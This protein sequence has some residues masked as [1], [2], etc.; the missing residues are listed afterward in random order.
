MN[1][2][3]F[4]WIVLAGLFVVPFIPFFV[5][6]SLFFPYITTKAF[7]WRIII[8]IIFASWIVLAALVPEYRPKKTLILYALL[9]FLVII[10][11]ADI[12]GEN[13]IKSI[14]SN[15]ER[16]EGFISL[17]HLGAFFVVIS[18]V[19]D[20]NM[21]K[22]WWNTNAAVS[23]LM[24]VYCLFQLG[25]AVE[26]HQGGVRVDGTF[27]NA[28]YLAVYMLINIFISILLLIRTR[29]RGLRWMYGALTLGQLVILYYTAT[30]G[31]ILGLLGGILLSALIN[32]FNK[33]DKR[34][35]KLSLG[36]IGAMFV[37]T[38]GFWAI[39]TT[40]FVTNSPVLSRFSS[41]NV[42]QIK[43]E[44]RSFIWPMA[45]EGIKEKP[46]LGWGQENF[47][48]VFN[49]HYKPEMFRL[50]PWFDR[51]HNIF[52][53]WAIAGGLLGLLSYLSL[54]AALLYTLWKK[55]TVLSFFEKSLMTGMVAAYFFH[56]FFVFDHLLSYVLFGAILAYVDSHSRN[57]RL[58]EN[59]ILK[60]NV[61]TGVIGGSAVLM[62]IALYFVNIEPL[63]GNRS[64]IKALSTVQGSE[65][66]TQALTYFKDA[67]RASP[68]GRPEVVEWIST[69]GSSVNGSSLSADEKKAYF[70]FATEVVKKQADDFA[71]DA[72]YQLLAG[73]LLSQ[74]GDVQGAATYLD[75]AEKLIPGKQQ[76]YYEEGALLIGVGKY[77]EALSIF[78]KAYDLAPQNNE[79]AVLYLVGAIYAKNETLMRELISKIPQD[80]ILQ[81]DSVIKALYDTKRFSDLA[82]LLEVRLQKNP[83]NAQNYINLSIAYVNSGRKQDAIAVLNKLKEVSP[84]YT[85]DVDQYIEAINEGKI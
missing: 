27:G 67:Y 76:V 11:L 43:T 7:S 22:K 82:T 37:L 12:L 35:K 55:D 23:A 4:K 42:N 47:N 75:R 10:G 79:A 50:E 45:I 30:R 72:R 48:Y 69:S 73:N 85:N 78:K 15:F 2:N 16:M 20:E 21:W 66:K 14:W 28:A 81:N 5:S 70:E 19:F 52:L 40:S 80:S 56:N 29:G 51:A 24:I 25:G 77:E 26:I 36:I 83:T 9:A 13:P 60:P 53:D 1:K 57:A 39:R 68:L 71:Q 8:E 3:I 62:L 38:L 74:I 33:E 17:L 61:I 58:L 6:S 34:L 44:G 64:L 84:Q 32:L 46:I 49:E 18:S 54:Y 59:K 65:N 41:I 63:S 31:A